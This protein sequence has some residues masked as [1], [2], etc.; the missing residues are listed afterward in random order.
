MSKNILRMILVLSI[1][2]TATLSAQQL[3]NAE[4]QDNKHPE[5]AQP[6]AMSPSDFKNK[7]NELSQKS[8]KD[9][10]KQSQTVVQQEMNVT[11]TQP[12]TLPPLPPNPT[13]QGAT[14]TEDQ[15]AKEKAE[16]EKAEKEKQKEKAQTAT[17]TTSGNAAPAQNTTNTAPSEEQ[18]YTGFQSNSGTN[19]TAPSSNSGGLNVQY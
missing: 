3:F 9:T 17:P 15:A 6:Q 12:A 11:Q 16:K 1:F 8:M 4:P 13:A 5:S 18:T 2:S 19:T 7:V 14:S 10:L